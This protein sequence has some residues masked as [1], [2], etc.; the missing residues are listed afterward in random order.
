VIEQ[1]VTQYIGYVAEGN[2]LRD[3]ASIARLY[4]Q[5]R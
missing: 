2:E 1:A 5:R 4:D 3:S